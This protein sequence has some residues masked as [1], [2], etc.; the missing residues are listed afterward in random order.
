MAEA[1]YLAAM[2]IDN[3]QKASLQEILPRLQGLYPAAVI[4]K[5]WIGPEI[6]S[7]PVDNFRFFIRRRRNNGRLITDFQPPVLWTVLAMLG[8]V[9]VVS[10]LLTVLLRT[11]V[12]GGMGWLPIV[13]G[14]FVVKAI[15]KSRNKERFDRFDADVTRAAQGAEE[16]SIF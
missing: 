12:I 10:V 4:K 16:G 2:Q 15:F 11:P 6:I 14:V 3:P 1:Y 9:V 5:P 8:V 13:L 7:I